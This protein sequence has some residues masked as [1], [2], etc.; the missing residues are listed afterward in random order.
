MLAIMLGVS[1]L[2]LALWVIHEVKKPVEDE[3]RVY[4][5]NTH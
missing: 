2:P 5:K 3:S 4:D 1:Y